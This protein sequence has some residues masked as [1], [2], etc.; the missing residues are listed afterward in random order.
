MTAQLSRERTFTHISMYGETKNAHEPEL[1]GVS[2]K[3][4]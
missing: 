1:A 4:S 2:Q 3:N